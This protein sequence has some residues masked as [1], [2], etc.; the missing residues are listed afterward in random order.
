[1]NNKDRSFTE[2]SEPITDCHDCPKCVVDPETGSFVC[3]L[4]DEFLY[5]KPE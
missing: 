3:T 1:M 2:C 5:E 4:K